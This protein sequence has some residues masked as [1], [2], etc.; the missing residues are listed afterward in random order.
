MPSASS[1]YSHSCIIHGDEST[2]CTDQC[3][4]SAI[5]DEMHQDNMRV[6][7][8]NNTSSAPTFECI[9]RFVVPRI[10][11]FCGDWRH[12]ILL[13]HADGKQAVR[14]LYRCVTGSMGEPSYPFGMIEKYTDVTKDRGVAIL[15][16]E[17][18]DHEYEQERQER[19]N[20]NNPVI[21]VG[22]VLNATCAVISEAWRALSADDRQEGLPAWVQHQEKRAVK[23]ALEHAKPWNP[24]E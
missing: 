21:Q 5:S 8:L 12:E 2:R 23:D 19:S 4:G 15:Q 11:T 7:D 1:T 14:I 20:R 3:A 22:E 17:D 9:P 10:G 6:A 16:R 18:F 13:L 24:A